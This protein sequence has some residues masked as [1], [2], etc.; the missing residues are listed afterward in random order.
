MHAYIY[1][2]VYI[3][4][5]HTQHELHVCGTVR[6]DMC[7]FVTM[8]CKTNMYI[9]VYIYTKNILLNIPR[10]KVVNLPQINICKNNLHNLRRY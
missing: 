1:T 4:N 2:Y 6:R 3:I 7:E 9:C 10:S 5:I 8:K